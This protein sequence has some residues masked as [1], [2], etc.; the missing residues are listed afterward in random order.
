MNLLTVLYCRKI[1]LARLLLQF[2]VDTLSAL[3]WHFEFS[4]LGALVSDF[5]QN[6][7]SSTYSYMHIC[8][9]FFKLMLY[10]KNIKSY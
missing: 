1:F 5:R 8:V 3:H 9:I 10:Y 7:I 2:I 6:E 4:I